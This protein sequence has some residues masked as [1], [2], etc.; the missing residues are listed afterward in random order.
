MN[1]KTGL[2]AALG[3][4]AAGFCA[5]WT[6]HLWASSRRGDGD[7][8]FEKTR[9][10]SLAE[11]TVGLTTNFF[12]TLGI[13]SFAPTTSIFRIG[14]MVKDENIPGTLN[15]GDTIPTFIEALIFIAIVAVGTKTLVL[16]IVASIMGAW[17]GAGVV[18]DL[19][20]RR[21]QIGMG[22][23][24]LCAAGLFL[25]SN[26][27]LFPA[28]GIA[29]ELS[30]TRLIL[31]LAGN[32][33]LGSLMPLGIGLYAPC[34]ILISLLGMDPKTS[35]PIMMG[36]CAFLMP[37]ASV[38]FLDKRRYAPGPALGLTLG[39]I[40]GVLLAAYIVKS[41]PLRA[42]RWLVIIVVTYTAAAMLRSGAA[43]G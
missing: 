13:G 34:M 30:G 4:F 16:M 22:I 12:D 42:L 33:I 6:A 31:G 40:P 10:P 3:I 26:L 38:R 39:G 43:R 28:G 20:K 37:V 8:D 23:A 24:L 27:G 35:F 11:M 17:L 18:A 15:V 1:L 32:F 25:M 29:Q 2:F 14:G 7:A 36:S 19:P 5:I 41:M 21:I 9:P